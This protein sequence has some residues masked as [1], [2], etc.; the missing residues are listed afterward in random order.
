VC[1]LSLPG[2]AWLIPLVIAG[3][4]F[5]FLHPSRA[6]L[7]RAGV[8]AGV[9]TLLAIPAIAAAVEW[10]PR[11][12]AF[13][14]ETELGNLIGKLSP[15][16]LFGIWPVD[17]APYVGDF[18]VHPHNAA[19][20]YVLIVLVIVAGLVGLVWA[21]TQRSWELPVYVAMA[22]IGCAGFVAA[23]SPWVGGKTLAMASPAFVVVAL[24]ACGAGLARQHFVPA[25]IVAVAITC[26]VLVSN[27]LQYDGVWLA[28]RGQLHELETI[29]HRY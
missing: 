21:W 16:Q 4:V 19:P 3:A 28:P 6:L 18:R 27:V 14:K 11:V 20:V 25:A 9:A 8:F 7:V 12:G 22:G 5:L 17:H 10:L 26:G 23:S 2:G 24:A 1:V 13:G 15:F 29:G